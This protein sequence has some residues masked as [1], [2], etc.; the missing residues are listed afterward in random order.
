MPRRTL[1][2]TNPDTYFIKD[3]PDDLVPLIDTV[4]EQILPT[5]P[6]FDISN[7]RGIATEVVADASDEA[8]ML[9]ATPLEITN[10]ALAA[11]LRAQS[12]LRKERTK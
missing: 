7:A 2:V 1:M 4:T 3:L 12:R 11:R 8:K 5:A 6:G 10:M 9:T